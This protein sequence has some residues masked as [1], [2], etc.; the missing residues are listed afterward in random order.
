MTQA[1]GSDTAL[2]SETL[3]F[4]Q[5]VTELDFA[6]SLG[7]LQSPVTPAAETPSI[8]LKSS[9]GSYKGEESHLVHIE[10]PGSLFY[11]N[12]CMNF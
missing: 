9:P 1:E 8:P 7:T 12:P 4:K 10:M 11:A 6:W 2:T 3:F 5:K